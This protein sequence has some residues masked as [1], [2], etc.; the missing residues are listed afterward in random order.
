MPSTIFPA[1]GSSTS[2][3]YLTNF[4]GFDSAPVQGLTYKNL[5]TFTQ[6]LSNTAWTK[7]NVTITPVATQTLQTGGTTGTNTFT[8]TST[9]GIAISQPVSGTG[10]P[11]GTY[12]TA[13]NSTTITVSKNFT[14][15][16]SG[17]Y[18]FYNAFGNNTVTSSSATQ[19]LSKYANV[20][21][22]T[23]YTFSFYAKI[24]TATAATFGVYDNTNSSNLIAPTSYYNNIN[25][26]VITTATGTSGIPYVTVGNAA[27]IYV[28]MAVTSATG[29]TVGTTVIGVTPSTAN[30]AL[31][32]NN[33]G[34]VSSSITF[35]D[36]RWQRITGTFTTASN[37]ANVSVYPVWTIASGFGTTYIA[38]PQLETGSTATTYQPV[39][40]LSIA[41]LGLTTAPNRTINFTNNIQKRVEVIK[42]PTPI[43]GTI[44]DPKT[45]R[46]IVKQLRGIPGSDFKFDPNTIT[47]F[48]TNLNGI[49]G[50]DY[51]FDIQTIKQAV[52]TLR[53][54]PGS[55]YKFDVQTLRRAVQ[56]LRGIPGSDYKFDPNTIN[57][58]KTII[59][60][61]P[62]ADYKFDI[63]TLRRAVQPLRG[64]P[65]SD[66]KFD[67]QTL[68]RALEPLRG[69]P[70]A[71]YKF[72]PNTI[73]K[74]KTIG[75]NPTPN[76]AIVYDANNLQKQF[77]IVKLPV[78]IDSTYR[79]SNIDTSYWTYPSN[80]NQ[81]AV[82]TQNPKLIN[83]TPVTSQAT[84]GS[85][86][87]LNIWNP[88]ANIPY[89]TS[90]STYYTTFD[91][92]FTFNQYLTVGTTSSFN[93]LH[94]GKSD[95]T[96]ESWVYFNTAPSGAPQVVLSTGSAAVADTGIMMAFGS[97]VSNNIALLISG[98]SVNFIGY[99]A[100]SI[101]VT[102]GQWYHVAWTFTSSTKAINLY[103]NGIS[104]PISLLPSTSVSSVGYAYNQGNAA[105]QMAIGRYQNAT[106]A[107]YFNG[108]I[109]NLRIVNKVVYTS[110]FTP[111][112]PLTTKQVA[113]TNVVAL[114]GTE[115][116]LLAL[117]SSSITADSSVNSF[118]LTPVNPA[119]Q[120]LYTATGSSGTLGTTIV[121]PVN[122]SNQFTYT[123]IPP[124][125]VTSVSV[126]AV[127][128]GGGGGYYGGGGGGGGGL[129][130]GN[131]IT[132]VPG[133]S[134]SVAVG[135][136]GLY[137][138]ASVNSTAGAASFFVGSVFVQAT[139]GGAGSNGGGV[140][141][142]GAGGAGGIRTASSGSSG[143]SGGAGGSGVGSG[144]S[145][146]GGG[147]GG[148]AG[149]YYNFTP[150]AGGAGNNFIAATAPTAGTAAQTA[151]GGGGGGA[152]GGDTAR[153]APGTGGS[154]GGVGLT[155][156]TGQDGSGGAL[157]TNI[158]GTYPGNCGGGGS[159]GSAG[160]TVGGG[161]LGGG[162]Y[163]G[164][165]G[166]GDSNANP[167]GGASVGRPTVGAGAVRIIWG[168]GLRSF[169][170][171][172]SNLQ[173]VTSSLVMTQS[174]ALLGTVP[175]VND[176]VLI[177]DT[178]TGNQALAPIVS[179]TSATSPASQAV[180]V[181]PT[182]T[183]GTGITNTGT[184]TFT[185]TAPA[186]VTSVSVVAVG[187]GGGPGGNG[188][189]GGGGGLGWKNNITVVPGQSYTVRAGAG[190][191]GLTSNGGDS[192]FISTATVKGG[193]GGTTQNVSGTGAGGGTYVGDGGGNGGR[194]G[195]VGG[196]GGGGG[197]GAGGYNGN[198][199]AGGSGVSGAGS[200]G[201]NGASNS[202][203]G[204][205]GG[206]GT[207]DTLYGGGV[208]LLGI[209]TTGTGGIGG[210]SGVAGSGGSGTTYGGGGGS[211][212]SAGA[213]GAVR[214]VWGTGRSY[215][216]TNLA[217]T[218]DFP[219]ITITVSTANI[220]NL[221]TNNTWA[222]QLW[223]PELFPQSNLLT[224]TSP[225]TARENLYYASLAR[226]RYGQRF[227]FE[228]PAALSNNVTTSNLQ[229][230][231]EVVKTPVLVPNNYGLS[232]FA[233]T[234]RAY[235]NNANTIAVG[236]NNPKYN[237]TAG[238]IPTSN[239]TSINAGQTT[240][241]ISF[242]KPVILITSGMNIPTSENLLLTD[243]IT[244]NQAFISADNI[245]LSGVGTTISVPLGQAAF[246]GDGT[247]T[248]TGVTGSGTYNSNTANP[249][250]S[251]TWT[252]PNN[253]YN[254]SVVCIGG[255]GSGPTTGQT[256]NNGQGG[257]GGA[258]AWVNNI[259]VVPGQSYTVVAGGAV[260]SPPG[261]SAGFNG[262]TSYFI[263]L[264]TI[265]ATGGTG[266]NLS[267]VAG[268][269]AVAS[270]G[271]T[272]FTSTSYGTYGGGNGGAGGGVTG[273]TAVASG[274]GGGGGAGG[275][276][277]AGGAG[278]FGWGGGL[279][280]STNP[281][282]SSPGGGGG[283]G[284]FGAGSGNGGIGQPGGGGG[285]GTGITPITIFTGAA[286]SEA[287]P[288]GY[289]V[290]GSSGS[291]GSSGGT[292]NGGGY[293]GGGAAAT[294]NQ[295][296]GA[297]GGG[298]AIGAVRI[299]WPGKKLLDS[300]TVRSY[301]S[302]TGAL[303]LVADQS[304][305]ITDTAVL[306]VYTANN[307]ANSLIS[308][309]NFSNTVTVQLWEF[310][311]FKQSNV[312]TNVTP[313]TARENLYYATLARGRYGQRFPYQ[314][315][316]GI[317]GADYKFDINTINK[318]KL[319][320]IKN[321][322]FDAPIAD[323]LSFI[324]SQYWT[325]Y[326]NPNS[327]IIGQVSPKI[328]TSITSTSTSTSGSNTVINYTNSNNISPTVGDY[329]LITDTSSS[330]QILAPISAV[331]NN[332]YTTALGQV[333]LTNGT[334]TGTGAA[335][336][337]TTSNQNNYT[338]VAPTGVFSVSVV[339]VGAGGAGSNAPPAGGGGALVWAN[340]ITV[341]PGTTYN[342]KSGLSGLDS[343][344]GTASTFTAGLVTVT[345]AGGSGGGAGTS[346]AGGTGGQFVAGSVTGLSAGLYGGGSGGTGGNGVGYNFVG[347]GG[348][349]AGGY[350]GNGGNG[351]RPFPSVLAATAAATGSGGGG[352][353]GANIS[354]AD[355]DS[356]SG[357]G[358][359]G[360][361]GIGAD[362]GAG[363]SGAGGF[364][365]PSGGGGGGS[366]GGNG[367]NE[368]GA[369]YSGPGGS[370]GGGGA[371]DNLGDGGASGGLGAVRIIW[372]A[373]KR[374]DGVSVRAFGSSAATTLLAT[375]QSSTLVESTI[376]IPTSYVADLDPTKTWTVQF[377]DPE[378]IPQSNIRTI[379]PP[380]NVREVL[381]YTTLIHG[382]KLGFANEPIYVDSKGI[383][384]KFQTAALGQGVVDVA[385]KP[386]APIQFWN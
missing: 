27:G 1:P 127:G 233:T 50:A 255:G 153:N 83:Y 91:T 308:N 26:A 302:T 21:A 289:G 197:G 325:N 364:A 263:D 141:G 34:T 291:G 142:S 327:I 4:A 270:A 294:I 280:T 363:S 98:D 370:Y 181:Y 178:V 155:G 169:P 116:S 82:G 104:T 268:T 113:R 210:A 288:G 378:V 236:Q 177:T 193:G 80:T 106:P 198:G 284:G 146:G 357:G 332:L 185:W 179:V 281:T 194:G 79:L 217:D 386:V 103:V 298:A 196:F 295:G 241:N 149:G 350:G 77:E 259:T 290:G 331:N 351:A 105:F 367:S 369:T 47:K 76:D 165:G 130:Y 381:Y 176:Y 278:G 182:T 209:G 162:Q 94:N 37:T 158:S 277:G 261:N 140:S 3:Q 310:D 316:T 235:L 109:S 227:P 361:L 60:A 124:V 269:S 48:K 9:T 347:A 129:A 12:V 43:D 118:T 89:M 346:G 275:Y 328:A 380:T 137:G 42:N 134:Y 126:V 329:V 221:N 352:G 128:G 360:V 222:Y 18:N 121:P 260:T 188:A 172:A 187:G 54:I 293:G 13:I 256:G 132:V 6:D 287:A 191:V 384:T 38:S 52:R 376:S 10:L 100:T 377:W 67:I 283:G 315:P 218:S 61:I 17:T 133:Q 240:T 180:A 90:G 341:T 355:G 301:G 258:L 174:S 199:G 362:G 366:G 318:F 234:Y 319:P 30:I 16:G 8:V 151:S 163:G 267:A 32:A 373:V 186:G 339:A 74:F 228:T 231:F 35:A 36:Q 150:G 348:G 276:A 108:N 314:M 173:D 143:M 39:F 88:A 249:Q 379:M 22:S 374:A 145:V 5:L 11:A 152:G 96:I 313:L 189:A 7:T 144:G 92:T 138:T 40:D 307:I 338:W 71:D 333:L 44:F 375:D 101:L 336:V 175:A 14:T 95:W 201:S 247:Y 225:Q 99:Q 81:V 382:S 335:F 237:S 285:G 53:G 264:T 170:G 372:P 311:L 274:G 75:I 62:G 148:G 29:V 232:N 203:A 117:Q 242:S 31:S 51:K 213:V 306:P 250:Y 266:G 183:S 223:D 345:A 212:G 85:N 135:N 312:K 342:I 111:M 200:V 215:P 354:N 371:G 243:T 321:Q 19:V 245:T 107:G 322:T 358:G 340:N 168:A 265:Y 365:G 296:G 20:S 216:S 55:D 68:R 160:A 70:G 202:G 207:G 57:K 64:I 251:F 229:K 304:G 164:G 119:G 125:G 262:G 254:V 93:F 192:Y 56:P 220:S 292:P 257:G 297:Q 219:L 300:S 303:T 110:N 159:G 63:Q 24:G 356:G 385:F 279:T 154:G 252:C 78:K 273:G 157:G 123:F 72:D 359:V 65:G 238:N 190:G 120:Q 349:G 246:F 195:D 84:S 131:N 368:G 211:G 309:I 305:T 136:G 343:T 97:Q 324:D 214:I 204:G 337:N 15:T 166:G 317:P 244:G 25:V 184:G 271:G 112:G 2:T 230:R 49:P 320:S 139:G 87:T 122:S 330:K 33:S 272:F 115:T 147:G 41:A 114:G 226:G 58:F 344:S 323:K 102:S 45:L 28:G 206:G 239:V 59:N 282:A 167:G 171:P 73:N 86:T 224:N 248:G 69:I 326:N 156:I 253:V 299:M 46:Q 66:Y 208:G 205:G 383:V 334:A 286:G 23:Q 161:F 353:G